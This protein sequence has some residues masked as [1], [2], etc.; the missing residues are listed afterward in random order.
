MYWW[1]LGSLLTRRGHLSVAL[2]WDL[3]WY[4]DDKSI[5]SSTTEVEYDVAS[6]ASCEARWRRYLERCLTKFWIWHG[7]IVMTN[8][9]IQ[10]AENT[11]YSWDWDTFTYIETMLLY[12]TSLGLWLTPPWEGGWISTMICCWS[13]ESI[14]DR[15]H[16]ANSSPLFV[17]KFHLLQN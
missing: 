4:F 11:I 15:G 1:W 10:L 8:S 3:P 14:V 5:A 16:W 17:W 6:M 13:T 2:A 7:Y 9:G 12:E